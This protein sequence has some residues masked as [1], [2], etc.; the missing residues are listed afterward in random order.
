MK[1]SIIAPPLLCSYFFAG[2]GGGGLMAEM[3]VPELA[4]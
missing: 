4:A 3:Q 1:Q 2:V